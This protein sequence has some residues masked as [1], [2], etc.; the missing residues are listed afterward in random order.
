MANHKGTN[1]LVFDFDSIMSAISGAPIH[2]HN[3]NL[4]GYV[5]DIRNLII[6][7]L[8]REEHIDN[9]WII[10]TKVSD[11]FRKSLIGLN[12][13]FIEMKSNIDIVRQR[14]YENPEGRNIE[15]WEKIINDY[16]VSEIDF[17]PFY[18]SKKWR[19]KREAILK[20][21]S[22]QCREAARFGKV[23]PA[24]TVHH[25]IPLGER[26]DLK[27][28]ERNLISLSEENHKRMHK[29]MSAELSKLGEEWRDRT[30]RKYSELDNP[31]SKI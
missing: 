13:E 10:T 25:V 5:L 3:E 14:L 22:Y 19:M 18:K 7:K 4:V 30:I 9:A 17:S 27:L 20:R 1:D 11:R 24:N 28:D 15:V 29:K 21:D 31:P 2:K 6:A 23:E 26:P 8:K 16:F 12:A